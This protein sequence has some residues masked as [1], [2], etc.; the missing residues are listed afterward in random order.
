MERQFEL[1][2]EG[3][4]KLFGQFE[5]GRKFRSTLRGQFELGGR[6]GT[7]LGDPFELIAEARV[8]CREVSGQAAEVSLAGASVAGG[9]ALAEDAFGAPP[10]RSV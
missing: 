2:G 4:I 6:R 1:G 9:L 10:P 5:L 7:S 8:G 3:L